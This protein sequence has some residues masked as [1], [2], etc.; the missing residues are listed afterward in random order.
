MVASEHTDTERVP[1]WR[2]HFRVHRYFLER[3]STFLKNFFQNSLCNGVGRNDDTVVR[4]KD[5]S[6][7]I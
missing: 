6:P 5:V 3:D 4:L 7:R 1:R 2:I